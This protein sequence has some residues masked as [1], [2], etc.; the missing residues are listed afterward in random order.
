MARLSSR[1]TGNPGRRG[2]ALSRIA[3]AAL[4]AALV[5]TTAGAAHADPA[6]RPSRD[7]VIEAQAELQAKAKA[8]AAQ[9][10]S[11]AATS[12]AAAGAA[13]VF[14]PLFGLSG[15]ELHYYEPD[16]LGGYQPGV[17]ENDTWGFSKTVTQTDHNAD[18]YADGLWEITMDGHLFYQDSLTE[19]F[20]VGGGWNI[21]N[22]VFSPGNLAGAQGYDLLARDGAG[23]LWIYLG[24]ETGTVTARTRVGAGWGEYTQI[25]GTG[26]ISGD[27]RADIVARDGS[28]VLWLYQGTGSYSAPFKSRVK[29]GAGWNTYNNLVG[30][31]DLDV[32][33]IADLVARG[34]DGTLW[35]YSG[36]ANPA[37]PYKKPVKIGTGGWNKF[38]SL[39]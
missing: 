36:N 5:G 3:V 6:P 34:N 9:D 22:R 39:F 10:T 14:Q 2:R 31:G 1:R 33:G 4:A 26:D 24:Y 18:G 7:S 32:D 19:P 11:R 29:I 20:H 16:W 38:R 21:Y 30:A 37:A 17:F 28:G 8:K 35:R 25:A 12:R 23:V 27:G 15:P 13:A